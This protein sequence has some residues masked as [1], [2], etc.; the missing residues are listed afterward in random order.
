MSFKDGSGKAV[1]LEYSMV[2]TGIFGLGP[3]MDLP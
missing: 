3:V 1:P 2:I